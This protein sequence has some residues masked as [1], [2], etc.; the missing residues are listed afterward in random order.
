M[1]ITRWLEISRSFVLKKGCDNDHYIPVQ[2]CTYMDAVV[3]FLWMTYVVQTFPHVAEN[4]DVVGQA[5]A[6]ADGPSI[7]GAEGSDRG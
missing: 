1:Y 7:Q 4:D 6:R 2:G 5:N 3:I